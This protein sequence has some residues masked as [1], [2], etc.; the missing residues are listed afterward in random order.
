MG[1]ATLVLAGCA[2]PGPNHLYVLAPDNPEIIADHATAGNEIN[3]VPSFLGDDETLLGLAYDPFTDHLFLRL[4]PGNRFRVVDRPDRSIKREF[5]A[6]AVPETGG[7]DLA[8]RSRDRHLFLGHPTDAAI[9]E[10]T[11]HGQPVRPIPLAQRSA[12]PGGIAYDQARELIYVTAPDG[13][14]L[15]VYDRTGQLQR[16]IALTFVIQPAVLAYDSAA[17]EFYVQL[18]DHRLVVLDA[19]GHLRRELTEPQPDSPAAFDVGPRSF[20]RIF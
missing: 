5:T 2:T 11:L 9:Y 1:G 4:A 14:A 6:P 8:I 13:R 20:L 17:R 3:E 12:P 15:Q 7:G 18:P 10:I 16:T 19:D